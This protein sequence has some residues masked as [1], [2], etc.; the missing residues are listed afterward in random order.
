MRHDYSTRNGRQNPQWYKSMTTHGMRTPKGG[1]MNRI[2]VM[3][4]GKRSRVLYN[5]CQHGT[6]FGSTAQANN[7]AKDFQA[8]QH[9][10]AELN[11][12]QE[13]I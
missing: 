4:D 11:L 8:D 10:Q 3:T 6:D 5:F 1:N 2:D 12:L 9:P 7:F 13:E